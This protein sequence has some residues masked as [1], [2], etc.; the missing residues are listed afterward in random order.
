MQCS[1]LAQPSPNRFDN[2]SVWGVIRGEEV[3]KCRQCHCTVVRKWRS[4]GLSPDRFLKDVTWKS[5]WFSLYRGSDLWHTL[6]RTTGT[7]LEASEGPILSEHEQVLLPRRLRDKSTA[8]ASL[9]S[10]E[11]PTKSHLMDSCYTLR[12]FFV[13]LLKGAQICQP[14]LGELKLIICKLRGCSCHCQDLQYW[15]K[16]A[17]TQLEFLLLQNDLWL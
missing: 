17:H 11:A 2:S 7:C 16:V 10:W 3:R 1:S 12:P 6:H 9:P 8:T 14:F 15:P 13:I 4:K 5:Y